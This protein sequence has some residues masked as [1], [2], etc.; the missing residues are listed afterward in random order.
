MHSKLIL[1]IFTS[2]TTPLTILFTHPSFPIQVWDFFFFFLSLI[3]PFCVAQVVF[4][5]DP[6]LPCNQP[7][8][9]HSLKENPAVFSLQLSNTNSSS[10]TGRILC[11]LSLFYTGI[12]CVCTL[13]ISCACCHSQCQFMC[14]PFLLCLFPGCPPPMGLTSFL[15]PPLWVLSVRLDD[16][17]CCAYSLG[18]DIP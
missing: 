17:E 4:D 11:L 9:G 18:Q 8:R 12:L 16:Y 14:V 5:V 10:A 1:K 6:T 3:I 15:P 2:P 13:C 7:T